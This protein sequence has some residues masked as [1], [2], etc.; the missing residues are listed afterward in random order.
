MEGESRR[1]A[2]HQARIDG[3]V[4]RNNGFRSVGTPE[5]R[6]VIHGLCSWA[7]NGFRSVGT[8][9]LRQVIYGL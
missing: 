5:F 6:Q 1:R 3:R 8:P 2:I 9:E 7:Q 4:R